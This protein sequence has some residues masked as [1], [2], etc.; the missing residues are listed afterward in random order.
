MKWFPFFCLFVLKWL[1]LSKQLHISTSQA[2]AFFPD[3][4]I[5]SLIL[6]FFVKWTRVTHLPSSHQ[7][8]TTEGAH[9]TYDPL[10]ESSNINAPPPHPLFLPPCFTVLLEQVFGDIFKEGP[11][12]LRIL[13][14]DDRTWLTSSCAR[15]VQEKKVPVMSPWVLWCDRL[16]TS[17]LQ[18]SGDR[19]D[20][21]LLIRVSWS[22]RQKYH[23]QY[24]N[25]RSLRFQE[26]TSNGVKIKT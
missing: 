14:M 5:Y 21:F 26:D 16:Y 9:I 22:D 7:D 20:R 1:R 15:G 10:K 4:A 23:W 18:S 3:Q 17:H 6:L 19:L 13:N 8:H 24:N 11:F 12:H 2:A 25:N